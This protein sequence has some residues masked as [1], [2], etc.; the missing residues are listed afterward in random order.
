MS[1]SGASSER[2]GGEVGGHPG[3]IGGRSRAL[4]AGIG[5]GARPAPRVTYISWAPH[6]SR[7][8]CT[9]RE[10]GGTSH[11]VY[12]GWLGSH[13]ATIWLKYLGQTLSTWRVLF[14]E[15]PDVVFVMS[16]PPVAAA[17]VYGYCAVRGRRFVVDAH[18]GVFFTERWRLFRGVHYWLCRR[19]ATTIVTN[20]HLAGLVRAHGGT[21]TVVP[22]VPIHFEGPSTLRRAEGRFEAVFVTSFD[23]DEPIA[24]MVEAARRL[25]DVD[26]CMTGD[27][28]SGAQAAPTELPANLRL[29]GFL[30]LPAYGALLRKSDVVI[31]L[32]NDDHTMQ[33]AAYEAIYQ[34][35]PVIVSSTELLKRAFDEGAVHVNNSPEAIV[36]AVLRIRDHPAAFRDGARRLRARKLAQWV[37]TKSALLTTLGAS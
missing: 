25:P 9:A 20:E 35:A 34:G 13:P 15:D 8:D 12:W 24:A 23:R 17:A 6:C 7:S 2:S 3:A 28:A 16:P 4:E 19:A 1:M 29:T 11:M 27:W 36:E 33:R 30:D 21:A 5:T 22:D 18:S 37:E 32:T 26:C 10:L 14:R 31:A